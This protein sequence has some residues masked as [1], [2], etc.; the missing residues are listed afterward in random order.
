MSGS[1][2]GLEA[3][4]DPS[5]ALS[6]VPI[7]TDERIVLIPPHIPSGLARVRSGGAVHEVAGETM[8]T[9]WSIRAVVNNAVVLEQ[10]RGRVERVFARIIAQMSTWDSQSDISRFNDGP[11]GSCHALET[12]FFH[13]LNAAL[14]LARETCGAYDPTSGALV[15]LWGFGAKPWN[16]EEPS[17]ADVQSV[18][19]S[20]GWQRLLFDPEGLSITQPGGLRLDLSSIA[21]GYA[22]DAVAALL[23]ANGVRS[24]LVEVG[25]ELCGEGVKPDGLPWWVSLSPQGLAGEAESMP[26]ADPIVAL[27]GFSVATSG[28]GIRNR[29]VGGKRVS[30]L[31]DPRTGYPVANEIVSIT[32]F[33]KS[34]MLADAEATAIC[35]LGADEGAAYACRKKL[36]AVF[37]IDKGDGLELRLTPYAKAM[38][39]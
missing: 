2:E 13:V 38:L 17:A 10:V 1:S 24:F 27:H 19:Q 18:L 15:D 9:T 12:E 16:G 3:A 37:T 5:G 31:I 22:V 26:F 14:R 7:T 29:D 4:P 30:H 23:K 20:S 39:D 35:V 32:V 33:H 36:A 6:P 28:T 21:K 34:C 8:G 11:A 25:G